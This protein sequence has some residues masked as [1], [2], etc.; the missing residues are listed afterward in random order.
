MSVATLAIGSM[1]LTPLVLLV[2]DL[3]KGNRH[4]QS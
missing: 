3:A 2:V 4:P 1:V